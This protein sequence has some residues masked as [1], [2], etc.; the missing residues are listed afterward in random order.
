MKKTV[1]RILAT[2]L[3]VVMLLGLVPM[4]DINI[5]ASAA[6]TYSGTCGDNLTWTLD[7]ATGEL[8]ISG[9]GEMYDYDAMGDVIP[10]YSPWKYVEGTQIKSIVIND[11]V[12]SIGNYAFLGSENI[13]FE[14]VE[15]PDS[16]LK[17]GE[18]AFSYCESLKD[19]SVGANICNIG[20]DAFCET[21]YYNNEK[22]W[23]N[24]VLYLDNYLIKAK[25]DFSGACTVVDGTKLISS[26]AFRGCVD[27]VSI[28]L[29]TGLKHIGDYAF[30]GCEK[31]NY[32]DIPDSVIEIGEGAFDYTGYCLNTS[33]WDNN[34]LYIGSCL[35]SVDLGYE[36]PGPCVIEEGTKLIADGAFSNE[37]VTSINI[38]DS[39][40]YICG[41]TLD[42]WYVKEINVDTDNPYFSSDLFGVLYNRDKTK[43]IE[44]PSGNEETD[45]EIPDSVVEIGKN[46]FSYSELL[47]KVVI[48][49]SV[50]K[51][52][53]DAFS[54][55]TGLL[56]VAI[57]DS[58][59]YIG[60]NVFE[61]CTNLVNVIVSDQ[62]TQIGRYTFFNCD[63]ILSIIIPDNITCVKKAVFAFCDNL[64]SITFGKNIEYIEY[65]AFKWCNNLTDIYY[66]GTKEEWNKITIEEGN[67][68]LLN[69]TI[70]FLGESEHTHSY[71]SSVTKEASCKETGIMTYTCSCGDAYTE[72]IPM[73]EHN[74]VH[75]ITPS[76]CK[77]AGMEYDFCNV[78]GETFNVKTLPL[79]AHTWGEWK[80]TTLP[81]ASDEGIST[82]VCS[83]CGET[84]TKSVQ[85]LG[86]MKDEKTG[87]EIEFDDEYGSGVEIKVEEVFDGDSFKLIE[88]ACGKNNS[89][90]YDVSTIK[91]GEKVQPD[92][93]VKVR[94]PIPAGFKT[95]NILVFYIDSTN[96][97]ATNIPATVVNGYIEFETDHFSYY[98]IVEK[99]G[100]VHSVSIDDISMSYKNSATITPNVDV[101]SNV[102]YTVTYS[103]SNN[104][105]ASVDENGKITTNGTCSATITVTVTDEYGNTVTDTCEVNV[106]YQWWQ[107]IIVIVLFGWIWY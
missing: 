93:K 21:G 65:G 102:D 67:E 23:S 8:V 83:V 60:S 33:N 71:S 43:L 59:T 1:K 73:K 37:Y 64:T 57:P 7:T 97:T 41:G 14:S 17:I 45:F 50:V 26:G 40:K 88:N 42:S 69:A 16:V 58:V 86:V 95:T 27:L 3:T 46:A 31:L 11:G 62:I 2:V 61:E 25:E 100:K 44:Y 56:E 89:E 13:D 70:H 75:D 94:I 55:C 77:V 107:W 105:V 84:E 28:D 9:E 15:I 4:T 32:V 74:T 79:N 81:T 90:I 30:Q 103:S 19:I 91:N 39:V 80:V 51:V 22:N 66:N 68:P 54:Q 53:D 35:I 98:A 96:G 104:A 47:E 6:E 10:N 106:S 52:G 36:S 87:I 18:G 29:P 85:K 72:V 63:S 38:P 101:D 92:G 82:R 48:P 76:T 12:T 5:T 20:I 99:L 49:S 78:C 34:A 24:N